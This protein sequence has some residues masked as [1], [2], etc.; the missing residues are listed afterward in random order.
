M[1]T[2]YLTLYRFSL[3]YFAGFTIITVYGLLKLINFTIGFVR[4][5]TSWFY[6]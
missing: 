5:T 2:H 6:I 4:K 1:K 3:T